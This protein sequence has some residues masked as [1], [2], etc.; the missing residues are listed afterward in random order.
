MPAIAGSVVRRI[1]LGG[2]ALGRLE[3][4]AD[5]L[6]L[7][8]DRAL[9]VLGD[10]VLLQAGLS[11]HAPPGPDAELL[12]RAHHLGGRLAAPGALVAGGLVGRRL[13]VLVLGRR[14]LV[15]AVEPG[16]LLLAQLRVG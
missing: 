8:R 6:A 14:Q 1:A 15:V 10:D 3:L 11:A 7:D 5:L 4:D 13:L 12:L 9:H 2:L 16:L